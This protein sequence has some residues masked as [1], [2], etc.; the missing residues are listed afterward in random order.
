[1]SI[2]PIDVS[3][4][5]R[6]SEPYTKLQG[7]WKP[8]RYMNGNRKTDQSKRKDKAGIYFYFSNDTLPGTLSWNDGCYGHGVSF[9]N[10]S[11]GATYFR[12]IGN[13]IVEVQ[14]KGF[15]PVVS[16]PRCS[17]I[18]EELVEFTR[19]MNKKRINTSINNNGQSLSLIIG[20]EKFI[21]HK[22]H[23]Y[24]L[25]DFNTE[26]FGTWKPVKGKL[27]RKKLRKFVGDAE[28]VFDL[29]NLEEKIGS[30]KYKDAECGKDH[31][32]LTYRYFDEDFIS[33]Q[34]YSWNSKDKICNKRFLLGTLLG[35]FYKYG[36]NLKFNETKNVVTLQYG[37]N[38]LMLKRKD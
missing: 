29:K 17:I 38:F 5:W 8:V 27:N 6:T 4:P 2:K 20:D 30:V 34:Y 33:F 36:C 28:V 12:H 32:N 21:L 13:G 11:L 18:N 22:I 9:A 23:N 14:S 10:E 7:F 26:L 19:K 16:R 15:E 37:E 24:T 25:P 31:V 35:E 1:L 3:C